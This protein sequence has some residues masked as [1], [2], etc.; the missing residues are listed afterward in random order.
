MSV[1]FGTEL[2]SFLSLS[3]PSEYGHKAESRAVAMCLLHNISIAQHLLLFRYLALSVLVTNVLRHT[4]QLY[5]CIQTVKTQLYILVL[6]ISSPRYLLLSHLDDMF[7]P[8]H[9][10]IF[11]STILQNMLES[12]TGYLYIF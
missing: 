2:C 4:Y 3:F 9:W 12:T 6:A 8:L 1:Q 11:R 5:L 10:A 7:Q